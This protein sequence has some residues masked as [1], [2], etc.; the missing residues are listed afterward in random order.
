MDLSVMSNV[1]DSSYQILP[2][3]LKFCFLCLAFFRHGTTIR[4]EKLVQVWIA[5]GM[6]RQGEQ[7]EEIAASYLDGLIS[8]YMVIVEEKTKDDR[9]KNCRIYD[10][11]HK[12][13]IKK[14]EDEISLEILTEEGSSRPVHKPRHRAIYCTRASFNYSMNQDDNFLRSLFFHGGGSFD[15][16][17]SYWKSFE[18]LKVLDFEGFGLEEFPEAISSLSG[19]RYLGLR[20]NYIREVPNSLGRLEC[21]EV[22][23]ISL[24]FAIVLP[25][26]LWRM[27]RLRHLYMSE[28]ICKGG[29]K[30]D[31]LMNLW[32]L[33]YISV[34]NW[35]YKRSSLRMMTSLRKLGVEELSEQ[36]L[37]IIGS[38]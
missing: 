34:D 12:P 28:M 2:S 16:T 33:A 19:L 3:Q 10:V 32:T 6:V 15:H 35:T 30:I 9:V 31:M 25:N 17:P 5:G 4:A 18:L 26:V 29:L 23:D 22:L 1:F 27:K 13:S 37:C 20:N 24:N 11:L 38:Q 8:R 7:M 36:S 21:L 14:A